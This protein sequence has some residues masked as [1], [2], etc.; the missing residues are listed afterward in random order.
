[1]PA[2]REWATLI[3]LS[4]VLGW[5]ILRGDGWSSIK[6]VGQALFVPKIIAPMVIYGAYVA[7]LIA[8]A[9]GLHGWNRSL[10]KDTGIWL[11][12][13]GLPL[14]LSLDEASKDGFFRKAF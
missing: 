13:V 8:I 7:C 2:N 6:G 9:H 3:W 5:F 14:L 11:L 4:L 1:M 10:T 12:T